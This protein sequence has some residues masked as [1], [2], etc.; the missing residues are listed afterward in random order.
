MPMPEF[1]VH[2][3]MS[4]N[5]NDPKSIAESIKKFLQNQSKL[6]ELR[7]LAARQSQQYSWEKTAQKTWEMLRNV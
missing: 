2:S 7:E 5:P 1:A 3:V 4:F 6:N